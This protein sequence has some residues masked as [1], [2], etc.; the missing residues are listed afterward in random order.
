MFRIGIPLL[1]LGIQVALFWKSRRWLSER[2][3]GKRWAKSLHITCFALFTVALVTVAIIRPRLWDMPSWFI[4]GAAYPFFIWHGA[5]FF[6]G[7]VLLVFWIIRLP[8]TIS[9]WVA[10][11]IPASR[12][13]IDLLK[14]TELFQRF[15][16]S[17][18]TFIRTGAYGLTGVSF[19]ASA[20]GV[21]FGRSECNVTEA[22]FVIPSLPRGLDGFTIG[23]MSD[24]HSSVY[25]TKQDM[26]GFV[27]KMNA[28]KTDMILVTG[29][30]VNSMVEEVYPFAEAFS[31]LSAAHGVYGVLGN[32]DFFTRNVD[33]IAREIDDCG[34]KLLRNDKVMIEKNG[35]QFYLLGVDDIGRPERATEAIE[36]ALAHTKDGISTILMCHR[37]YFLRQASEKNID[38]VLSGH[39]HGGQVSL[40]TFGETIIAPASLASPYVWGKYRIK[41]T[42][43]YVNRGIGTVGLPIR[44][45]CPPEITVVRLR[46]G[47]TS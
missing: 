25:M 9:I 40:G 46:S 44:I 42:H 17:R 31:Q 26:A 3:P 35:E 11:R 37:P 22:E 5:T 23:L 43:M 28:L 39:T 30:F 47:Q 14:T 24:I 12:K 41:D 8:L 36:A 10:Q 16:A 15:D 38:L 13:K 2:Y 6:I 18:R 21:L 20:Y 33:L 32:H 29:D 7:L 19:G 27:Q 34:L 45:N 1:L 4:Y